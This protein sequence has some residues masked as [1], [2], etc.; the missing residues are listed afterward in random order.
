[1]GMLPQDGGGEDDRR[2]REGS[3]GNR[4]GG[5]PLTGEPDAEDADR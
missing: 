4:G 1:M 2:R 3:G 5:Y